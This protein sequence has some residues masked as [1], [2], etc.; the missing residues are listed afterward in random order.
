[1]ER[2]IISTG[3]FGILQHLLNKNNLKIVYVQVAGNFKQP[4]RTYTEDCVDQFALL[5]FTNAK[6]VSG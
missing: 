3:N 2:I 6:L 5:N 1:M 4:L